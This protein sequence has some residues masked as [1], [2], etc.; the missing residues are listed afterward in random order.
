MWLWSSACRQFLAM[1]KAVFNSLITKLRWSRCNWC[2]VCS[3]SVQGRT[4]WSQDF[5]CWVLWPSTTKRTGSIF[6]HFVWV[7]KF[8]KSS[9]YNPSSIQPF[10]EYL[11]IVPAGERWT[12]SGWFTFVLKSSKYTPPPPPRCNIRRQWLLFDHVYHFI[13]VGAHMSIHFHRN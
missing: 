2:D 13:M 11:A 4:L 1:L 3:G 7:T 10:E 5:W 12:N 6:E 8:F 9:R